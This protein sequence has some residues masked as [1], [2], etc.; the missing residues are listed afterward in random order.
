MGIRERKGARCNGILIHVDEEELARFDIREAGYSRKLMEVGQVFPYVESGDLEEAE[1]LIARDEMEFDEPPNDVFK[2]VKCQ[3]CRT[4][5]EEGERQRQHPSS[6]NNVKNLQVWCYFQLTNLPPDRAFPITQSYVDII[7]RGCLHISRNFAKQFLETTQG[8]W[9]DGPPPPEET[10]AQFVERQKMGN[11]SKDED[12]AVSID[13]H[14]TWLDDRHDPMYARADPEYSR[15]KGAEIDQLLNEHHPYAL[16][17]R[18][19][20]RF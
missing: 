1:S 11:L 9:R 14:H 17:M 3:E 19:L 10:V 4:A 15:G 8:W 16:K 7:M 12:V 2:N 6:S 20:Y 13:T 18:V 5:F